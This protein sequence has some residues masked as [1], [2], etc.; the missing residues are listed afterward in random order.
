MAERAAP[1]RLPAY[2]EDGVSVYLGNAKEVMGELAAE[3]VDC[4]ITSP[5]YWGL[6]DFGVTPTV[7]GG[8][9]ECSHHWSPVQRGRRKDLLPS[10]LT[11]RTARVGITDRQDAAAT[12]GGRFCQRCQAWLG[13][14]G[15]EPSPQLFVAHLVELFR[16]VRRLLKPTG[17]VWLNLGDTFYHAGKV[18]GAIAEQGLKPKD[19]I[20]VPW[21]V[22][23]ALQADG[24]FLRSDVVWHKPNPVPEPAIDRPVRAHE[25]L[26]L[27]SKQAH[28]FYDAEAVREPTVSPPSNAAWPMLAIHSGKY[29]RLRDPIVRSAANY[30][31]RSAPHSRDRAQRSVWT[32]P[33]EPFRGSHTAT[34]PTMLVEPCILAGTSAAGCCSLCG[35]PFER[36]LEITYEPLSSRRETRKAAGVFEME[37]RQLR[38]ARTTG[39][40]PTCACGASATPA[41]VLDP[42]AGT[43]T[44]LAVARRLG[45]VAVGIELNRAYLEL[46]KRRLLQ[47]TQPRATREEAA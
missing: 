47:Q 7:W 10:D 19:L 33:T 18:R 37:M 21:R 17:V 39:W 42:F 30:A 12:N 23:L 2:H 15:L 34:F 5:P 13:S 41:V 35:R 32:I 9:A 29:E 46:I 3:G 20:G 40:R 26:F 22:A 14:L 27:L 11:T 8:S 1:K 28:Y 25:F 36:M 16:G 31:R 43:G 45:R 4:V 24:W 44:A 6:R 38:V